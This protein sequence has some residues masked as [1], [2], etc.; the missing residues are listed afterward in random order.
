MK[1]YILL[2]VGLLIWAGVAIKIPNQEQSVANP[3]ESDQPK[4][5]ASSTPVV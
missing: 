5:M 3:T 1:Q 2:I 4:L